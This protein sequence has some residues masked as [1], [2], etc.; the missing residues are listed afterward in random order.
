MELP[1][2]RGV[3]E[4]E[5]GEGDKGTVGK[6]LPNRAGVFDNCGSCLMGWVSTKSTNFEAFEARSCQRAVEVW[7]VVGKL[8]AG[9]KTNAVTICAG[10]QIKEPY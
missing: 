9:C 5:K 10:N 7:V 3:L 8:G 1:S 4:S 6:M 2:R